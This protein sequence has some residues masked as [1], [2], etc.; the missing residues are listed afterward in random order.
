M[1]TFES[2][3]W[4]ALDA[5]THETLEINGD[6]KYCKPESNTDKSRAVCIITRKGITVLISAE[7]I[8]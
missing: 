1:F 4:V 6:T 7:R 8:C 3:E 5:K 2:D